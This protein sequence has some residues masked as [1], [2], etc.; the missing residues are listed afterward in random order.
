MMKMSKSRPCFHFFRTL[1]GIKKPT[2]TFPPPAGSLPRGGEGGATQFSPRG[3][4][5]ASAA[6]GGVQRASWDPSPWACRSSGRSGCSSSP[7]LQRSPPGAAPARAPRRCTPGAAGY[8]PLVCH[9][10]FASDDY[11]RALW[12]HDGPELRE[13]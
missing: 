9:F 7:L 12:V 6:R 4:P 2:S 13:E 3:H 11:D 5:S 10:L 8:Y 1:L